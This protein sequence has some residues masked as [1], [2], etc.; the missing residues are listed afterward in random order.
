MFE[1][2]E[3]LTSLMEDPAFRHAFLAD[4]LQEI[5]ATQI[6]AI[7]EHQGLTQEQLGQAAHGMSQVQISRLENPDYS[8]A[9]VNSLKRVA[10]ALDVGLIIRYAPFSEFVDWVVNQSAEK[11]VPPSF[12]EEQSCL[13]ES[14]AVDIWR[15][16]N[17]PLTHISLDTM[18]SGSLAL[19]SASLLGAGYDR[20]ERF[21][22]ARAYQASRSTGDREF[23]TAA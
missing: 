12:L 23:A 3:Q 5:L 8:G 7:R 9:S 20:E 13:R 17:G 19:N 16:L 1:N 2:K 10:Q 22:S 15:D 14:P 21:L 6:K 18:S 4:Y 11:F